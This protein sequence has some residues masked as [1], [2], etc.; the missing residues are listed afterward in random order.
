MQYQV[1]NS[2]VLCVLGVSFCESYSSL[3][4]LTVIKKNAQEQKRTTWETIRRRKGA[5]FFFISLLWECMPLYGW[6]AWHGG[7]EDH[8]IKCLCTFLSHENQI[9]L[10][11]YARLD[12]TW[13]HVCLYY[14]YILWYKHK[15]LTLNVILINS[16]SSC[17]S[18][19]LFRLHHGK[20]I[21]VSICFVI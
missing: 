16:K 5:T 17:S 2:R 15:S 13:V 10:F 18:K 9:F 14:Y 11:V 12:V 3:E 1:S 6:K 7:D 8:N 21:F 19:F 4:L 20:K